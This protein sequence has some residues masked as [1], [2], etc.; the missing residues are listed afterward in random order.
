MFLKIILPVFLGVLLCNSTTW[1]QVSSV[2]LVQGHPD[3][4]IYNAKIIT[5]D[6]SSFSSDPGTIA[7]A[8]AVRGDKILEIGTTQY[9]RS[10]AGPLTQQIDLKGRAVL[11]GF[12]LTH[13]HPTDWAWSGPSALRHVFPEGNEHLVVRFLDGNADEQIASWEKVLEEAVTVA[14]PGQWILLSSDFG[15]NFEHMPGLIDD[16]YNHLTI[17]RV[18]KIAPN[19]P[20]RVKNSWP[21]SGMVNSRGE[22]EITKVF[23]G[24]FIGGEGESA[25][26]GKQAETERIVD[27]DVI[28]H[29][30]VNLL[31]QVIKSEMELWAAHGVT[32]FGSSP[33]AMGN[34]KALSVLDQ[35]EGGMP[36]RFAW[37]YTGPDEH[38]DVFR[39]VSA[40]L[41]NGTDYLW[42]IGAWGSRAGGS[43]TTL[44]ASERV[45]QQ[46][47]C[48]L[49]PGS[50]G[51]KVLE[52]IVRS[53]GR[54]ATMHTGGDK[55]IDNL[56]DIIEEQSKAAGMSIEDIRARRHAFDHGMGAPRPD[57]I[58][59]VKRL[60]MMISMINTVLWENRTAYDMAYRVKNYGEEYAHYTVPRQSVTKAGIMS[61]Q[62]IDRGLPHYLFYNIWVG[63]TRYNKGCDRTF[64]PEE[65]TDL[66]TQL[67]A[68]T[69]WGSYY[70]LREDRLG[71]LERGKLADFVVLDRDILT[72][73]QDDIP[74]VKVNMTVLGG[75][76]VHLDANL[77]KEIGQSPVGAATWPSRPLE[78]R[79]VFKGPPDF[80]PI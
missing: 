8:L 21:L 1:A 29:G 62:E 7:E 4:I 9:I 38:F 71:S 43:C 32:V 31:A 57:Q 25:P 66:I 80:C 52:D 35:Q 75:K 69:T 48:T 47:S 44:A 42:N 23:P 60:G 56:M 13:E 19:N 74:N 53:G 37:G 28:L 34:L 63:M 58:P 54:I 24:T 50:P 79:F 72:I 22:E 68:L 41:G 65:G 18:N 15:A 16:F 12:I 39:L 26:A 78:T 73:P 49:D 61:T 51:R 6:D 33:Y 36:G 11:P 55:D 27:P 20:V 17:E 3:I 5:M 2:E 45:K 30:K 67:K 40:L 10:L 59:R 77:A 70:V 76:P 14:K 64:A 46:E